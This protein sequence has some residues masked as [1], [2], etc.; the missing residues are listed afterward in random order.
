MKK[1]FGVA[2]FFYLILAAACTTAVVTEAPS[3]QTFENEHFSVQYSQ[4]LT[5]Y[6][7]ERPSADGVV[8]P[9]PDSIALQGSSFLLTLTTFDI[10]PGSSLSSFIDSHQECAALLPGQPT[11]VGNLPAMQFPDTPCGLTGTTYIY[12]VGGDTGFRFAI[13]SADA[14]AA[15]KDEVQPILDSFTGGQPQARANKLNPPALL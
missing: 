2:L 3:L 15:V 7:N 14:Y 5:L 1:I 6:E 13:E 12:A 10:D 4:D 9:L 8:A 11:A